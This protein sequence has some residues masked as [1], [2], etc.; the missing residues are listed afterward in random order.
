M[1]RAGKPTLAPDRP[2]DQTTRLR[3]HPLHFLPQANCDI[4]AVKAL[5][6]TYQRPYFLSDSVSPAHF[7]WVLMS[8]NYNTSVYK[9]V[10][11]VD[12]YD[13]TGRPSR[14]LESLWC[15]R[16]FFQVEPDSGLIMLAQIR[17]STSYRLTPHRACNAS[18]TQLAGELFEGEMCKCKGVSLSKYLLVHTQKIF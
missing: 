3:T 5:R 17:G 14:T 9:K 15:K 6:R 10:S 7:N 18:C 4:L 16:A 13:T 11:R 8:S 2:A 12:E 1:C